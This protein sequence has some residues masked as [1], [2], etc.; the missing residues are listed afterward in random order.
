MLKVSTCFYGPRIRNGGIRFKILFQSK[1]NPYWSSFWFLDPRTIQ[2][3]F[4][5]WPF[6][7]HHYTP[8][9]GIH[10]SWLACL[11]SGSDRQLDPQFI[12]Y[13]VHKEGSPLVKSA[14]NKAISVSIVRGSFRH[15]NAS[16]LDFYA[17]TN[18]LTFSTTLQKKN[19][20][21]AKKSHKYEFYQAG[22][23]HC[24]APTIV[25]L[26]KQPPPYSHAMTV[27]TWKLSI[28]C[29]GNGNCLSYNFSHTSCAF[30]R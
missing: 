27:Y 28:R 13:K 12:S 16:T 14:Q 30:T 10:G 7:F 11:I 8:G 26:D 24:M 3:H 21:A 19:F 20:K 2:C 9:F 18:K 17:D 23:I 22:L 4:K 5:K 25:H 1:F 29:I 6:V 15:R